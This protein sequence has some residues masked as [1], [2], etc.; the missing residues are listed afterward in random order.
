MCVNILE[1]EPDEKIL[2]TLSWVSQLSQAGYIH[3]HQHGRHGR[4]G[5]Q[6]G[7][8]LGKKV[9]C[10]NLVDFMVVA[11]PGESGRTSTNG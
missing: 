8:Q 11:N 2:Q 9:G 1:K 7:R 10:Q 4:C 6:L 5:R 3:G